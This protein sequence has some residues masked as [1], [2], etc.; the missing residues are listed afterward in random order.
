MDERPY[1]YVN[2]ANTAGRA[3]ALTTITPLAWWGRY[4]LPVAFW[5]GRHIR[6]SE[7]KLAELS[8]IQA[9]SW[10]VVK[11]I[12]RGRAGGRR[13]KVRD[14]LVF[15]TNFN[16]SWSAYIDAFSFAVAPRMWMAWGSSLGFPGARPT[17]RF[18]DYIRANDLTC[19]Y[20]FCAYPDGTASTTTAALALRRRF[21]ELAAGWPDDDVACERAW[22]QF[23]TDVQ[24]EL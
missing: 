19:D 24:H 14:Q 6:A 15:Q 10:H 3:T 20:Y 13:E 8:F 21:D 2:P 23:L 5:L 12:P 9:A 11:R 17:G 4:W 1:L 22:T 16:D 18:R 7:K